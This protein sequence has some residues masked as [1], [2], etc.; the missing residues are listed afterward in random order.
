MG[1]RDRDYMKRPDDG[2]ARSSSGSRLESYFDGFLRRH[3]R[4]FPGILVVLVVA[5]LTAAVIAK[6]SGGRR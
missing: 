2:D 3:P 1:I 4:L 5:I 6:I